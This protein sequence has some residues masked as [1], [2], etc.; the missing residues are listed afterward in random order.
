MP[1]TNLET[2]LAAAL[3]VSGT[4]SAR[5]GLFPITPLTMIWRRPIAPAD[6][7]LSAITTQAGIA[8]AERTV[9]VAEG[10]WVTMDASGNAV[11]ADSVLGAGA[12]GLAWPVFTGGDRLDMKGGLTV[13]HGKWVA[14]TSF[15]DQAGVYAV[16]TLLKVNDAAAPVTVQG[17]AGINGA[18]TPIGAMSAT[19]NARVVARVERTPIA[20]APE[21]PAGIIQISA[22]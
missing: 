17:V 16:G 5:R 21:T 15:F 4:L 19:E 18:L 10:Q 12:T 3:G 22:V 13:L 6:A 8:L 20:I 1:I 9:S 14:H 7:L 2:S 11:I